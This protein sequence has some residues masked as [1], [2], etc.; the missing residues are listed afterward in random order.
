MR[1]Q[2]ATALAVAITAAISGTALA[3]D[4]GMVK[5][6]AATAYGTAPGMGK[7]EKHEGDGISHREL[8]ETSSHGT[9]MVKFEDG[10]TLDLAAAT[11]ALVVAYVYKPE[12]S[13]G[14]AIISLPAGEMHYVTGSMPKGHTTIYTPTATM[15]LNGTD[16]TIGVNAQGYTHLKV[17]EGTVTVRSRSTGKEVRYSAGESV[18]ITPEGISASTAALGID[19]SWL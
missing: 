12:A 3:N 11:K 2:I 8:L 16:V 19:P 9:M 6:V 5:T 4:V 17:A 7:V 18:D 15:V 1:T 14:N 10:S 13:I